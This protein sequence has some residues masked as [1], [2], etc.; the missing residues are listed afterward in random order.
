MSKETKN[1]SKKVKD[2]S[3]KSRYRQLSR[4]E[5]ILKTKF[6]DKSLLNM[7]LTHRSYIN[8]SGSAVKDNER[9]E[10]LGDS[11]LGFI[12]SDYLYKHYEG[13]PEGNL[14]K[15]KSVIVSDETLARVAG[16]LNIGSFIQMGRGE[17]NSGGRSRISILANTLESIIGAI[18]LDSG[19]KTSRKF[20]MG[21]LR[22]EIEKTVELPSLIDAKTALQEYVQK[23]YKNSPEYVVV[24]EKGPDHRKEFVV[25]LIVN[26]KKVSTGRGSSKRKAEM[27]AAR[28]VM[29]KI[30]NGVPAI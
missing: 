1:D 4:L 21:L 15:I 29:K 20:I 12:I 5:T 28:F 10:H 3:R 14:A 2:K 17:E 6:N 13:Y 25:K 23:K 16:A 30:Y 18:Y 9:L 8:E 19:I 11:V 24:E 27:N 26:G 22:S 7:A